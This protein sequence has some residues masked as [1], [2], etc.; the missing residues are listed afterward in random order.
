MKVFSSMNKSILILVVILRMD[1][2]EYRDTPQFAAIHCKLFT[3][4]TSHQE[5][6]SI[7][8]SILIGGLNWQILYKL[9]IYC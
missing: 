3:A 7:N 4:D 6:L 2:S 9:K 8:V 5:D 1:T